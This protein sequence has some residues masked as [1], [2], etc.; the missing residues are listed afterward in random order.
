V[1]ET[2]RSRIGQQYAHEL[3][4]CCSALQ[5]L[6]TQIARPLPD[7]EAYN[8]VGILRQVDIFAVNAI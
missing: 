7:E 3:R 2:V 5:V 4:V 1:S 6:S 8:I